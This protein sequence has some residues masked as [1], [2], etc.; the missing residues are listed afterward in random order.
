MGVG[1]LKRSTKRSA[2]TV[3][4]EYRLDGYP[5][6]YPDGWYRLMCSD[7]LR[8]GQARYLECLGRALV[9]WRREDADDVFAMTAFCPHLGANLAAGRV[10]AD[11]IECPFHGWQFTGDGRAVSVPYSAHVPSGA[12][13]ETFPVEEV[14]GHIFMYH[15]IGGPSRRA[16]EEVP[17]G[18]PRV[19]EFDDGRFVDRGHYDAGR[20]R[21]HIIE[22]IE[23]AADTAHFGHLHR[24]LCVPWTKVP[25]P[26]VDLE[27][28]ADLRIDDAVG[29]HTI[30]LDVESVVKVLDRRLERTRAQARATFTGPG[31]II[32][33]RIAVPDAGEIEI[34][35]TQLPVAPFEQQVDF[36]WYAERK[37]PRLV[38]WWVVGNWVSQWRHDVGIWESKAFRSAPVLCRDDGP[39]MRVRRWYA[40]FFPETTACQNHPQTA[41]FVKSPE[42]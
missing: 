26:G 40:Q 1:F 13:A 32:N 17:F 38:V 31:S 22:M 41:S 39:V 16:D 28:R 15:R 10:C 7:S 42:Q 30:A 23:N 35:Q 12:A 3:A 25:V 2:T 29:T 11:R 24:G 37:I 36:H 21:T 6:P 20:T 33:F 27:H 14:H 34:V 19:A 18:V 8:R 9:L 5:P 4:D